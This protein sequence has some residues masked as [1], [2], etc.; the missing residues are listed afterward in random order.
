MF[1][2]AL[3]VPRFQPSASILTNSQGVKRAAE[4]G[5]TQIFSFLWCLNPS[6]SHD[7][8]NSPASNAW[9]L[10]KCSSYFSLNTSPPLAAQ[11]HL[12]TVVLTCIF[13]K[14]L[15]SPIIVKTKSTFYTLLDL[16]YKSVLWLCN[17]SVQ[18]LLQKTM[19]KSSTHTV[20]PPLSLL[21]THRQNVF[22]Q[23]YGKYCVYTEWVI[24]TGMKIVYILILVWIWKYK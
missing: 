23:T 19:L 5:Q 8:H 24:T 13:K 1:F 21:Y 22:I 3:I 14:S 15:S 11:S 4:I 10:C 17:L 12:E 18:K 7:L 6:S 2:I 9:I 20:P 16:Y